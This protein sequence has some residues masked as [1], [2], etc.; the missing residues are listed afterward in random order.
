MRENAKEL[1]CF[2]NIYQQRRGK[3]VWGF[4]IRVFNPRG[5]SITLGWAE[6][7]AVDALTRDSGVEF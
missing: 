1:P 7:I 4:I 6:F 5:Q 2:A 3:R